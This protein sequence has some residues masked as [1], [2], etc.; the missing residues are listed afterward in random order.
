MASKGVSINCQNIHHETALHMACWA[1]NTVAVRFLVEKTESD[2]SIRNDKKYTPLDIAKE[3][4]NQELVALLQQQQSPDLSVPQKQVDQPSN[5]E[6]DSNNNN[7]NNNNHNHNN[8]KSNHHRQNS[9]GTSSS[10]TNGTESEGDSRTPNNSRNKQEL[11]CD[12]VLNN[13]YFYIDN[14]NPD[15][16]YL[17]ECQTL[18]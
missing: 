18:R 6:G 9:N 16:N 8:N 4:G 2:L 10:H 1:N 3:N 11:N 14:G 15:V 7:N 12:I 17:H 5:R 13:D